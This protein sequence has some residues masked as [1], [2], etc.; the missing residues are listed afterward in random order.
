MGPEPLPGYSHTCHLQVIVAIQS[1]NQ[2]Q[3]AIG[4]EIVPNGI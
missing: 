2:E 3:Q 1:L 4:V